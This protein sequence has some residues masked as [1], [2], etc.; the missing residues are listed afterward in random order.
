MKYRIATIS[1]C[2]ALTDLRM[3]MRKELDSDFNAEVIYA[4]TLDFFERNIKSGTHIAY[5]CEHDGQLI[6]TAGISLF[7]MMPTTEHPNGRAARLMNMY[8]EPF[9]RHR[10]IAKEL[11]NCAMMYAKEHGIGKVMLNPSQMGK[12]LYVNYGFQLLA[13]EYVFYL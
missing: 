9:Y 4:E 7:E 10:G 12:P 11:L 3:R 5:V 6:A 1:E 2:E 8:V 13:D